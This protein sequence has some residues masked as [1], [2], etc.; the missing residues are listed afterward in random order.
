M[1]LSSEQVATLVCPE[2]HGKLL[3]FADDGF[4]FCVESRLK[5]RIDDGVPVLLVEEAERVSEEEAARL[6]AEAG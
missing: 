4:L 3:Y 6:A 1:A 5:Y 2:S